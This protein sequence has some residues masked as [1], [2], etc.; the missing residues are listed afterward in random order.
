[1]TEEKSPS[2][3]SPDEIAEKLFGI[4]VSADADSDDVG[5]ELL[6]DEIAKPRHQMSGP[7][8]VLR[9]RGRNIGA[10]QREK[11][12]QSKAICPCLI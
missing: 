2:G 6:F 1:M 3:E 8:S 7:A 9:R 10:P 12:R 5:A 4:D 11:P